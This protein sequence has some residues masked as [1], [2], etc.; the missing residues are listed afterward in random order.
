MF[1]FKKAKQQV[2]TKIEN[3]KT[4]KFVQEHKKDI[5]ICC[6]LYVGG[7]VF[8]RVLA[9]RINLYINQVSDCTT[10]INSIAYNTAVVEVTGSTETAAKVAKMANQGVNNFYKN[11]AGMSCKDVNI[12]LD[13]ISITLPK[14]K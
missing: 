11:C 4:K 7:Y 13:N 8:G 3:S 6:G 1:N 2:K 9:N 5:I 14:A 12:L 10:K